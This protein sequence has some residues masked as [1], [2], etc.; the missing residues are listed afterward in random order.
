[1]RSCADAA[2]LAAAALLACSPA[3]PQ[4]QV[5]E[6]L[7]R[8]G[9]LR[10]AAPGAQ[11]DLARV[12]FSDVVVSMDGSRALVVAMVEADGRVRT[13]G[14]DASLAYVGRE[15]FAMRRCEGAGWCAEGEPVPA[16]AGVL[17]ALPA[18]RAGSAAGAAA[19]GAPIRTVAW[20]VRIERDRAV[21]GEDLEVASGAG[22]VRRR[23]VHEIVREG[24]GWVR[25]GGGGGGVGSAGG[26]GRSR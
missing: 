21:V 5:R 23:S 4:T 19:A 7:A 12:R 22:P 8:Q 11:A 15:A 3:G 9:A 6:A 16:L 26:G 10:V 18:L 1:L 13:G 24:D 17:A 14:D 2:S 20:Q 25:A